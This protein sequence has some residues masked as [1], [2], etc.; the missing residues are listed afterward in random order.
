VPASRQGVALT[1]AY[2]VRLLTIRQETVFSLARSWQNIDPAD[3]R[4]GFATWLAT[5][6][7]LIDGVKRRNVDL[8]DTY[9]AAYITAELHTDVPRRNPDAD[10]YLNTADGRPTERSLSPALFTILTGIAGGW[11]ANRALRAGLARVNRVV[12]DGLNEAP[13]RA[14]AELAAS[15]DRIIAERRV[16]SGNCCGACLASAGERVNPGAGRQT[17]G[18]CRCTWEPVLAGV[19]ERFRR[20]TGEEIFGAMSTT[21]QDALFRGRGGAEKAE[22]IRS[23][24]VPLSALVKREPQAATADQFTEASLADLRSQAN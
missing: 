14:L 13:R 4:T 10:Q 9:L 16:T 11:S 15:D 19:P 24:S 17:H 1:D 3:I 7:P 5:A 12:G 22:L 6:V 2:R 18:G 8:T 20:P 21:E 23:G